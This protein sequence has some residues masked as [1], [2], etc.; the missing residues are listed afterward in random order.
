M[1][2]SMYIGYGIRI[3]LSIL[4]PVGIV[5]DALTG[6]VTMLMLDSLTQLS[7]Q[8]F[9]IAFIGTFIQGTLMNILVSIGV[10]MIWLIPWWN[11]KS[12]DGTT[13]HLCNECLHNLRGIPKNSPCP[14]CGTIRPKEEPTNTFCMQCSYDLKA[15]AA[16]DPCP[17]CGS[18]EG[19]GDLFNSTLLS[20]TP[21]WV[22]QLWAGAILLITLMVLAAN[23]AS[24]V[25]T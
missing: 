19:A 1:R 2:K 17:E 20:K 24:L 16:G 23:I 15:T 14:E 22:F 8:E 9:A 4:F 21:S 10:V 3:A 13:D 7:R 18:E 11:T 5:I 12:R 25:Y 6:I